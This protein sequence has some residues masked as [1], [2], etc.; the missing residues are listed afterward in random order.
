MSKFKIYKASAGSGKTYSLVYE[1]LKIL[2]TN[3]NEYKHIL[4][5]TFTNE[6]T[7]EMKMRVL[8]Q[9]K[10]LADT[11]HESA[12]LNRLIEECD[13]DDFHVQRRAQE[14]LGNILHDYSN[15]N[16]STIDTF[17]Q[18]I[19]RSFAKDLGISAVYNLQLDKDPAIQEVTEKVIANT[20]DQNKQSRWLMNAAIEKIEAGKNWNIRH[21]LKELFKQTFK[22]N[23]QVK[24][25]QI[26]ESFVNEESIEQL[27]THLKVQIRTFENTIEKICNQC[28]III[29]QY[30]LTRSSFSGKDRSF[31]GWVNKLASGDYKPAGSTFLKA[32]DH[33]DG[34]YT[35]TT[36]PPV[37]ESIINA[38]HTGL[39]DELKKLHE[40][41][42]QNIS[43]YQTN[44]LIKQNLAYFVML[45]SLDEEMK[46]YKEENDVI[47]ISDTNQ[48]IN[49][50]I[51]NND[52]SFIFEKAGNHF[53][54]YL[55]DEFQDT[56][57]LQWNNFKPLISNAVSQNHTSLVVGDVKQSIYRFRNGDWRLLHEQA[58]KDI[59]THEVI[60]LNENYRSCE[61]VIRFNNTLYKIAPDI[62]AKIYNND[63][64]TLNEWSHKF[65]EC[66][67]GQEQ[68]IPQKS[69][70]SGGYVHLHFFEKIK[71]D[72][73]NITNEEQQLEQ[74][75]KDIHD[76]LHRG[77]R[78]C[79]IAV[80]VFTKKQAYAVAAQLRGFVEKNKLGDQLNIVTQSS[81]TISKAHTVRVL[82][83]ALKYLI[84]KKDEVSLGQVYAEYLQYLKG[85]TNIDFTS[86]KE[87]EKMEAFS[88]SEKLIRSMPLQ[89]LVN[90]LIHLFELEK[91][92]NEHIFLQH[93]KDAIFDYLKKYPDDLK[94]FLEWW[95]ESS[96]KFQVQVPQNE[97]SLQIIT[98]HKSKG[99]EFD[100]V[101]IPFA[102]WNFDDTG[103]KA[104]LL[105]LDVEKDNIQRTL[106]V[107]YDKR[108]IDT[109]FMEDYLKNKFYNYLDKLNLLYVATTRAVKELYIYTDKTASSTEENP[110]AS[111]KTLLNEITSSPIESGDLYV[112]LSDCMLENSEIMEIGEKTIPGVHE[113][114]NNTTSI[115]VSGIYTNIF[116]SLSIKKN[117][118]DLRN[119]QLNKQEEAKH[120][121]NLFHLIV[122]QSDSL[123]TALH[124]LEKYKIER[125]I[126]AGLYSVFKT[127][128]EALFDQD[129]MK[130]LL[131]NYSNYAEYSFC[132]GKEI[133]KP[134]KVLV[135]EKEVIVIDFKTG[136][137]SS[138]YID[139]V[140]NYARAAHLIFNKPVKG[141]LYYTI[142]NQFEFVNL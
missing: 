112:S 14:S 108:M 90:H 63:V 124:I 57:H 142:N 75:E 3:P 74:L 69:V 2:I 94:T 95:E 7:G 82:I 106:P 20:N 123:E 30:G 102:T 116:N 41:Y 33:V 58:G 27:N 138:K 16:I 141:Y 40:Y 22:E 88:S 51:G 37:K 53:H 125:K 118:V 89:I 96:D 87:G 23:Y 81:L 84:N 45:E 97:K 5:V 4:A 104:D 38:Y 34:W 67:W 131:A 6:A 99:L 86:R 91:E 72:D 42:T 129:L 15:F 119:E 137:P 39:N 55:I 79:D 31:Y 61:N 47:F 17:F 100:M 140:K 83:A 26:R 54:H 18:R 114:K 78:P 110:R 133:L 1:Y 64:K 105:W 62:I 101:F 76:A 8:K 117:A 49:E 103:L 128:L 19:L 9:L 85:D 44:E 36:E 111:V 73:E 113:S 80:L 50:I 60:I 130:E 59:Q 35:K 98:I 92:G 65:K 11:P 139:Q 21:E 135:N 109:P 56:S 93:F 24:E 126:N 52:E 68:M 136:K 10:I 77:Y 12:Y 115:E 127:Q 66:Y 48:F 71:G 29:Q 121:G 25:A 120:I 28:N 32:L 132:D 43:T 70:G 13:A 122:A 134:D 46:N 107:K